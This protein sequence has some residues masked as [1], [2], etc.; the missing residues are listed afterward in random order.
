VCVFITAVVLVRETFI[1]RPLTAEKRAFAS[2]SIYHKFSFLK[3]FQVRAHHSYIWRAPE[4]KRLRGHRSS[5]PFW[6]TAIRPCQVSPPRRPFLAPL[7]R[8]SE[9]VGPQRQARRRSASTALGQQLVETP[10]LLR[11]GPSATQGTETDGWRTWEG[12]TTD[13][14]A[15]SAF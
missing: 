7:S 2:F 14:H 9:N 5:R 15:I 1:F 3:Q 10:P 12:S 6:D 8:R 13:I 11:P 4:R